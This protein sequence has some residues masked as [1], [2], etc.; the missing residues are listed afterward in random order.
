MLILYITYVDMG[1][2]ASGSGVRPA[3]MYQAFL[4]EGHEV[5]LLSGAQSIA[6]RKKR[7]AAA[8]E[9]CRWLN[10][11]RPDIC[12]IESPYYPILWS[13]DRRL[14]RRIH[15]MGIPIGYFYRDF[16]HKLAEKPK[17]PTGLAG[18]LKDAVFSLLRR[19]TDR[20]LRCADI[21]Y[22]PSEPAKELFSYRDMR[23]LPP[24]GENRLEGNRPEGHTCIYVGGITGTY[25]GAQLLDTF[26]ILN[27][28]GETYRLIL[29]CRKPEWESFSHPY[30]TAPWLEVHHVSGEEL[31]PLY[32][33]SA[34]T[35]CLNAP[36]P[37]DLYTV[38]VKLYE[39]MSYGLPVGVNGAP[40]MERRTREIGTGLVTPYGAEN[41][42]AAVQRFFADET[43]RRTLCEQTAR[44]LLENNLW[45][46][47]VR[48]VTRELTERSRGL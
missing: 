30:K 11:N 43:L 12:D 37:Y 40:E 3:K 13:F 28:G 14:I 24:A 22:L 39:Y 36:N 29:V 33:R 48:Q 45:N 7:R 42:A 34:L 44:A 1:G 9:V 2:G 5:K 20:L 8:A 31:V 35:L 38:S 47:R 4:D 26:H 27:A 41:A 19:A 10:T 16:P 23:P 15:R 25:D 46:H 17:R 32:R 18:K 21:V 6:A